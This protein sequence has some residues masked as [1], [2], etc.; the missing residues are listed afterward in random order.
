MPQVRLMDTIYTAVQWKKNGDHPDDKVPKG[1]ESEKEGKVVRRFAHPHFPGTLV[2]PSCG[3]VMKIHGWLD[4]PPDGQI[5]CPGDYVITNHFDETFA[6]K[7]V[8]MERF[9]P[10]PVSK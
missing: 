9:K 6:I 2:C 4:F 8:A 10:Q 5:V 7:P 3:N 1:S